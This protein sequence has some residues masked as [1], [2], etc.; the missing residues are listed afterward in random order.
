MLYRIWGE[1]DITWSIS[2]LV[3]VSEG[4]STKDC[5]PAEGRYCRFQVWRTHEKHFEKI[6][7]EI[8][9]LIVR[10]ASPKCMP[11]KPGMRLVEIILWH[12][13]PPSSYII[14]TCSC[15]RQYRWN[16]V[17]YLSEEFMNACLFME[18]TLP[19]Q[20]CTEGR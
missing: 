1:V 18:A 9:N 4:L 10:S 2:T 20:Y 13:N 12:L 6:L 19:A 7:F 17:F 8:L 11:W 16:Q 15:T 14:T 5:R 3:V